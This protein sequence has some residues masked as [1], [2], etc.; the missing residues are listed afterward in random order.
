MSAAKHGAA[1]P[2]S[3]PVNNVFND[4]IRL[5]AGWVG[6]SFCGGGQCVS[7]NNSFG[8]VVN[9]FDVLW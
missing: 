3:L 4:E 9:S 7:V 5:E 2:A 8:R 1:Q 6:S